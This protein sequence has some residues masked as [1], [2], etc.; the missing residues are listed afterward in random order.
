MG[1]I[2]TSDESA[3]HEPPL[4]SAAR[5]RTS[6]SS[7]AIYERVKVM[8]ATFELRPG[9][10][11]N[12]IELAKR[13]D[14]S[15]TP[16]REVL[17]QL[18]VEGF[19]E[20]ST[21]KGFLSRPLDPKQIFDLY[22]YRLGLET[23]IARLACRRASD[24]DIKAL[25]KSV[26]RD[27]AVPEDSDSNELLALD[28]QFHMKLAHLAGNEEFVRALANANSR[29]QYVRWIDM[30]GGRRPH[31]QS[32]HRAIVQALKQRDEEKLVRLLEEHISRRQDQ[33][34]EVIKLGFSEIYTRQKN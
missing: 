11:I 21:N 22:E 8:A 6:L 14:V 5:K 1:N 4:K 10:R 27:A 12:E 15:R 16:L 34:V 30:R 32:E 18:M 20:R 19:L 24:S 7:T 2:V 28:E 26:K 29:I 33:I 3:T 9:E 23:S 31:T 25:E 13:L 17:N